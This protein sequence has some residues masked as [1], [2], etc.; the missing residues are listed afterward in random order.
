MAWKL[1][2]SKRAYRNRWMTVTEDRLRTESGVT[3]TYGVV[4]RPS[5]VLIIPWDGT[6]FTLVGQY[7]Y[8]IT[9]Y[10]WEFPQGRLEKNTPVAQAHA[11]LKEETGLTAKRMQRITSFHYAPAWCSE[12]CHVFLATGLTRGRLDLEEGERASR[13]RVKRVTPTGIRRLAAKGNLHNA[14][15]LAGLALLATYRLPAGVSVL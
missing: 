2:S 1:L 4:R 7:R 6:Y 11:E 5:A 12:I 9:G 10:S 3:L 15:T 13:W 8:A 14:P